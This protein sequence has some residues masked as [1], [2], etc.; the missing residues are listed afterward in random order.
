MS[1]AFSSQCSPNT[2]ETRTGPAALMIFGFNTDIKVEDTVYHVQSEERVAE[3]LLQTQVFV[4]GHC[5]G[6][7]TVAFSSE[8]SNEGTDE[9]R[10]EHL[11]EQHRAIVQAIRDGRVDDVIED[12]T[13]KLAANAPGG[14]GAGAT[15]QPTPSQ[16]PVAPTTPS[17]DLKFL[18]SSR[19]TPE[20][21]R[22]KFNVSFE[23]EPAVNARILA[24]I[25][26]DTSTIS[27]FSGGS[28][29]QSASDEQGNAEF[30]MPVPSTAKGEANLVLQVSF[31]NHT[32]ARK[33]RVKTKE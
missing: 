30:S 5:I 33:F 12:A 32:L 25:V 28:A 3:R 15:T 9:L 14:P 4:K 16:T 31:R 18:E 23:G 11:R 22:F 20:T 29:K 21:I 1:L 10:H 27:T 13:L 19:P 26:P 2:P 24:Q 7:K 17:L 6:K 8:E